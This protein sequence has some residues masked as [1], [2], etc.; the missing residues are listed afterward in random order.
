LEPIV[1]N[2]IAEATKK[3]IFKFKKDYISLLVETK[4]AYVYCEK[5]YDENYVT[6]SLSIEIFKEQNHKSLNF[7]QFRMV[8]ANQF[9]GEYFD[10][11]YLTKFLKRNRIYYHRWHQVG[12]VFNT[13]SDRDIS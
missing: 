4:K 12:G 8:I 1:N 13:S 3:I 10:E 9:Y 5:Y 11:L 6:S 2:Y 7:N